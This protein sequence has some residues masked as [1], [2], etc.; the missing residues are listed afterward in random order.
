MNEKERNGHAA[1]KPVWRVGD[2]VVR[3]WVMEDGTWFREG[4]SC[5]SNSAL[6]HGVVSEVRWMPQEQHFV[7]DVKWD[8]RDLFSLGYLGHGFAAEPEPEPPY[9]VQPTGSGIF[10]KLEDQFPTPLNDPMW[11]ATQ[12]DRRMFIEAVE[13]LY[14]VFKNAF[15]VAEGFPKLSQHAGPR[16][17]P[18]TSMADDETTLLNLIHDAKRGGAK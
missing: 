16:E 7:Y 2:R 11:F 8:D 9:P 6:R 1:P 12:S 4:D 10:A 13:A 18:K 3:K 17:W 15:N 14:V 5:L